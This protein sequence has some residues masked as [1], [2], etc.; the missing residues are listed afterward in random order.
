[1]TF[2]SKALKEM[3]PMYLNGR[4]SELEKEELEKD[5]IK[6]P[7]LKHELMEFSEIREIYKDIEEEMPPPSDILYGKIVRNIRSGNQEISFKKEGWKTHVG[8]VLKTIFFSPKVSWA[9]VAVQLAIILVL[10]VF[11]PG[12]KIF[13]TLTSESPVEREGIRINVV[14][15]EDAKEREVRDIITKAKATIVSGPTYDG[16]YVLEIINNREIDSVLHNLKS[17]DIVRFA[18]KTL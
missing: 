18:E 2:R 10:V 6:Y 12:E 8:A 9:V 5:L 16:L 14:F 11:A 1:M 15:K 7:E 17:S 3:I 13:R 4:L